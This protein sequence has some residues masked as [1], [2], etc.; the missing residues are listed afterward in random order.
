MPNNISAARSSFPSTDS[1]TDSSK[2]ESKFGN[3]AL[4][5]AKC[6]FG[7]SNTGDSGGG[8]SGSSG[9]CVVVGMISTPRW[10]IDI[11]GF[12]IAEAVVVVLDGESAC[13]GVAVAGGV[14]TG[15]GIA[16]A[17]TPD[18]ASVAAG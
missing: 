4:S 5:D 16:C 13:A 11:A 2:P 6:G 15:F 7:G 14:R 9:G 10:G 18:A 8:K 17:V 12:G 3:I 1:N